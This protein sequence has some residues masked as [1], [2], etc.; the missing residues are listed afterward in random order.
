MDNVNN[1]EINSPKVYKGIEVVHWEVSKFKYSLSISFYVKPWLTW[2][3]ERGRPNWP[4]PIL[5][6]WLQGM[7]KDQLRVTSESSK[8]EID[9]HHLWEQKKS[10]L[11]ATV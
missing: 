3:F 11:L 10:N 8:D 5:T 7:N 9:W 1:D 2:S 6:L 4:I